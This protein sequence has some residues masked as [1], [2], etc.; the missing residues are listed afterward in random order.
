MVKPLK[1]PFLLFEI[2]IGLSLM[3][4]LLSLLFSFMVQS[5]RVEKKM[6]K[7]RSAIL[8]RQNLQI[9]LQDLFT[10]ISPG[11]EHPALYTQLFPK[12]KKISLVTLFDN[13]IDPDPLFS[14]IVIGRIYLDELNNLCLVYWPRDPFINRHWRKEILISDISD[15]SFQF[16]TTDENVDLK[17]SLHIKAVWLN[18][19]IKGKKGIPS[20]VRMM[21]KQKETTLQFAFRLTNSNPTPTY[22]S[23][24]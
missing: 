14:G 15:M 12:E 18:S 9:R 20:I 19:W 11:A 6:E 8:E 3:A 16:L 2:L 4:I 5:L 7:A 24:Q 21:I 22:W 23:S 1:K 13:G 10:T 17:N